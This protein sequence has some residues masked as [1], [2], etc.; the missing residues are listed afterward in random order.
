MIYLFEIKKISWIHVLNL[1]NTHDLASFVHI[2]T[3]DLLG[4][5]EDAPFLIVQLT[6]FAPIAHSPSSGQ[7]LNAPVV[8]V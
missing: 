8:W 2:Q 3:L 1:Q 4:E 6:L 7:Y 5:E